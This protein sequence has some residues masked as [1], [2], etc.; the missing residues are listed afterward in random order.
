M[1]KYN[2]DKINY[3]SKI[4]DWKNLQKSY[5]AIALNVFYAKKEEIYPAQV[6]KVA[7]KS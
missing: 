6:S 4:S 2:L 5:V 3:P 7:F 1:N